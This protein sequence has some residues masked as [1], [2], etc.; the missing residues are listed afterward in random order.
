M[1]RDLKKTASQ[2]NN[3]VNLITVLNIVIY[4]FI[5]FA[6]TGKLTLKAVNIRRCF[7]AM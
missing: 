4:V 1:T 7:M 2:K 3:D 5:F 6:W